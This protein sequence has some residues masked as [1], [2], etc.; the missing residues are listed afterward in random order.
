[1]ET[2]DQPPRVP[3]RLSNGGGVPGVEVDLH[4]DPDLGL[5]SIQVSATLPQVP[6]RIFREPLLID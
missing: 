2:K 3:Q 4:C 5:R 6:S 1:M